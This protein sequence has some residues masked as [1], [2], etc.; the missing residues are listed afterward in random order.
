[1]PNQL[2][3]PNIIAKESLM[4]LENNMVLG[5]LIHKDFSQ[6]FANVGDT[7]TVR[8][9]TTFVVNE[10]DGTSITI[11]DA[12]E[13]GVPVKMDKH[14]DLSFKVTSKDLSLNISDF[15][16]QFISPAMRAFA[17]EVDSRIAGLYVDVPYITGTAGTAP[18]SVGAIT[19]IRK[20]MNDNKVPLAGRNLILDT[21]AD[22]KLLEVEN[23]SAVDK[24]G[25]SQA[26]QE[27][28]LGRKFGF[29]I[30]MDQNIKKHSKGSLT[31]GT[32]LALN[33]AAN[34]GD[35]QVILKDTGGS[36]TGTVKKGDVLTIAGDSQSYVVTEDATAAGNLVSVKLYPA[37]RVGAATSSAVTVVASHAAN[38]AFHRN[39]FCMV[40][41]QLALPMGNPNA[42]YINYNGLGLRVV[43]GYDMNTKTD[44]V[45]IDLLCGFK[46]L[47]PELAVRLLG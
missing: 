22:A 33:A 41:R 5:N 36:L 25:T 21:A 8:K 37:L 26:L 3:T 43:F 30:Y 17:Q 39:A 38:L 18:A 4:V 44:I 45:S 24:S 7:I 19:G 34:P 28:Q 12:T 40:S 11:Q 35:T 6:E 9:P 10:F 2:L 15:S 13:T 14:L 31:A 29:D 47:T 23:F 42:S 20:V 32:A 1:M 46:T 27:A 16:Q